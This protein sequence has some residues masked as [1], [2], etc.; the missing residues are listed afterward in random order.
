MHACKY[1]RKLRA[2]AHNGVTV[3]L[4]HAPSSRDSGSSHIQNR[5][6]ADS[7]YILDIPPHLAISVIPVHHIS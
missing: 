5:F 3:Y 4:K 1:I 7:S 2:I 6:K